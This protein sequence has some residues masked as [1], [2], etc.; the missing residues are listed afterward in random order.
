MA[1]I[2]WYEFYAELRVYLT[3]YM[4]FSSTETFSNNAV[5]HEFIHII[6]E[7]LTGF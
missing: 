1:L 2:S 4:H 3:T 6:L 7:E 5:F